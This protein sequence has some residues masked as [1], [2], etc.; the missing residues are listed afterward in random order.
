M[1]SEIQSQARL[2]LSVALEVAVQGIKIRIGRSVITLMGIAL[3]IAFLMSILMAQACRKGVAAEMNIRAEAQRMLSFLVAETGPLR[4]RKL[5]IIQSGILDQRELRFVEKLLKEAPS[6]IAL[7]QMKA[8]EGAPHFPQNVPISRTSDPA[9]AL[10]DA[11]ATV[12]LGAGTLPEI[13]WSAL[14]S[15]MRKRIVAFSRAAQSQAGRP[16]D[17]ITLEYM[18]KEEEIAEINAEA[19]RSAFRT[20]WIVVISLLVTVIGVS[21]AMLMSVTERFREIGTMKCLGALS[22]FIRQLFLM[23]SLMM[24]VVGSAIGSVFGAL[25]SYVVF[26]AA[27]GFGLVALSVR[28]TWVG[29]AVIASMTAGILLAV[30][31]AIYPAGFAARM[32]PAT[33]LRSNV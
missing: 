16:N 31:A 1:P 27:Y 13:N 18:P 22:R 7:V 24:G 28:W 19:R 10:K 25:F 30:V 23:E 9:S 14:M 12:V 29:G 20:I 32:V 21:N 26:G 4:G 11:D 6:Q 8:S 17:S 5:A 15:V 2:P 3:G 33:A